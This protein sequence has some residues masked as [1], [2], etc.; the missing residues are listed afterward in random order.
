MTFLGWLSV[1]FKGLS[2]LQ[3]E[4]EKGTLNHLDDNVYT[5]NYDVSFKADFNPVFFQANYLLDLLVPRINGF[6]LQT[7]TH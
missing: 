4:D 2:D 1:S 7:S 5:V 3:L 6:N